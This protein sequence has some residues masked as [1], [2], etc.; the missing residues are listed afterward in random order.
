MYFYFLFVP[1]FCREFLSIGGCAS[2][3]FVYGMVGF[4]LFVELPKFFGSGENSVMTELL[5]EVKFI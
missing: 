2:M 3:F 5:V 4:C 1:V